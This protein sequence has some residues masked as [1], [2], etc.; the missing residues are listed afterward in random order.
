MTVYGCSRCQNSIS[1]RKGA[2]RYDGMEDKEGCNGCSECARNYCPYCDEELGGKCECGK[3]LDAGWMYRYSGDGR[4]PEEISRFKTLEKRMEA[5]E[6]YKTKH[7]IILAEYNAYKDLIKKS[8]DY[9]TKYD[10]EMPDNPGYYIIK[11][12]L[13]W[14]SPYD[15][16]N[17]VYTYIVPENA[18]AMISLLD[19]DRLQYLIDN[20]NRHPTTDEGWNER[21]CDKELIEFHNERRDNFIPVKSFEE[22]TKLF[23]KTVELIRETLTEMGHL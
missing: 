3:E 16:E 11:E 8:F 23:R 9:A 13:D 5:L 15:I 1:I 17:H 20:V 22:K 18:E 21:M 7:K 19:E 2:Y 12:S 10:A 14:F 4:L 6:K